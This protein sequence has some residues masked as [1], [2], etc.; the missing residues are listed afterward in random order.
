MQ[1]SFV[2]L[3][4]NIIRSKLCATYRS[5]SQTTST[6]RISI[7]IQHW[8][9]VQRRKKTSCYQQSLLHVLWGRIVLARNA[10]HTRVQQQSSD[11]V[12]CYNTSKLSKAFTIFFGSHYYYLHIQIPDDVCFVVQRQHT[13]ISIPTTF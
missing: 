4:L 9:A 8:F 1:V 5:P 6:G 10:R 7:V 13:M 12:S 2:N 11:P 3:T